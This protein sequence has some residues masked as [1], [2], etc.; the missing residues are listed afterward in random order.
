MGALLITYD[1]NKPGQNYEALYDKIKGLGSSWWHYLDSTWIVDTHLSPADT[2]EQLRAVL[3]ASDS[4]LILNITNDAS[5]GWL[6]Q[7]AWNWIK[8]HV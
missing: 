1:L 8:E 2:R 3:D 5:D 4:L 7:D 6:E